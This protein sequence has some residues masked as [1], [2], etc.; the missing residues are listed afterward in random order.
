MLR[1]LSGQVT[2]SDHIKVILQMR[3]IFMVAQQR[4]GF[5]LVVSAFAI[6]KGMED[7]ILAL[8]SLLDMQAGS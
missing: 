4:D 7:D 2:Y 3:C 1:A 5:L 6:V 8:S